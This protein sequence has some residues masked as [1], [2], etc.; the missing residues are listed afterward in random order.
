VI[1]SAT[2]GFWSASY[3]TM[4]WTWRSLAGTPAGKMQKPLR[5]NVN[6]KPAGGQAGKVVSG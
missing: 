5:R 1:V 3:L 2:N 4:Q 6:V